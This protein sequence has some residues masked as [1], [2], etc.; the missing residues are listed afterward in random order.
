MRPLALALA[1]TDL[2]RVDFEELDFGEDQLVVWKDQPFTGVAVEL[3]PDGKP[4]SEVPFLNG[5]RHGVL[6]AWYPS[7]QLKEE[8]H[9]WYGGLHGYARVW[10]E[11]G[12][13]IMDW[14]LGP[15]DSLYGTLEI[16]RKK[17]G[18]SAPPVPWSG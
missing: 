7:G 12:G 8:K 15:Q 9:L 16:C 3:F 14:H 4:C 11:Q 2:P 17:W 1:M 18:R 10:N 13:L 6:R 5:L